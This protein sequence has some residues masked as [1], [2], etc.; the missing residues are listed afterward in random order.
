MLSE[1]PPRRRLS[2][3]GIVSIALELIDEGGSARLT[4]AAVAARAGV[5][6]PSLYKHVRNLDDLRQ[7]VTVR[8]VEELTTSLINATLGLSHD[9]ALRALMRTV[10]GNAL[11]YPHRYVMLISAPRPDAAPVITATTALVEV[12]LAVLRGY[13]RHGSAAIHATRAVRSASH[14]FV[15]LELAGGFGLAERAD[16]SYEQLIDMVIAG[17]RHT[18]PSSLGAASIVDNNAS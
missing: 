12:F 11:S 5:A 18:S 4:L 17:L 7:L 10:R 14:G 1:P 16:D 15:A 3:D 13:G 9:D 8:I 6:S 2:P